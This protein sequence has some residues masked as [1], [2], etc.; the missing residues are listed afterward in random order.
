MVTRIARHNFLIVFLGQCSNSNSRWNIN[1]NIRWQNNFTKFNHFIGNFLGHYT[2]SGHLWLFEYEILIVLFFTNL[3]KKIHFL[4]DAI[5]LIITRTVI[6]LTQGP[7]IPSI[8]SIMIAWIPIEE[9]A[10]CCSIAYMGMHV[11]KIK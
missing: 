9:R 6:G 8:A 3:Y 1:T 7:L 11:N 4:G 10:R 5:G 2:N